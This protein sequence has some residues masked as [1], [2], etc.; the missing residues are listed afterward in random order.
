MTVD[1]KEIQ[2]LNGE[3]PG[4]R[5]S[6]TYNAERVIGNGS[7]GIVYQAQVIETNEIVAIK[8]VFQDKRYKNRELQ[9]MRDLKHPSIVGLKHAFFT[10][11]DKPDE[12]FLNVVMEFMSETV[13]GVMKHYIK[14][15][16][17]MPM[18][19]I[20][21][22][23]YQLARALA[24][25]HYLGVCH[26]DI[27]PQN[28]L[29]DNKTHTL[30]LCDFGSAKQLVAGESNVAYICSRYYRAPELIFG[31]TDYTTAIDIWSMGCVV[32][33]MVLGAPLF[34]G[35][36]GVDQLVEII[37]VLG[38]PTRE[39]VTAMNPNYI[40]F[41]FPQIKPNPWNKVFKSRASP[42][43]ISLVSQL[44][45]YSPCSRLS[46][47]DSLAHPFFDEIRCQHTQLPG[48]GPLPDL[49]NFTDAEKAA[50]TPEH[51]E[52]LV[53]D[54]YINNKGTHTVSNTH[55]HTQP[56]TLSSEVNP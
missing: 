3:L 48:G 6:Y 50:C 54:W 26:R 41:K 44:L 14:T 27:K 19:Y 42:D 36:S 25:T 37:R 17:Q 43:V 13:Y 11:G 53:P 49:F 22:Y 33:E 38:T 34:P 20:K 4:P 31:A 8:K 32:A 45:Q 40:D 55:T 52:K 21:L 47:M 18:I 12:L 29:V 2:D 16:S 7:F 39:Q 28:L 15:K 10:A 30:K 56:N 46:P 35:E 5:I 51:L 1:D 23:T 9:I 24:H